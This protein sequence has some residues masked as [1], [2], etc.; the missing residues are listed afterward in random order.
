MCLKRACSLSRYFLE[1]NCQLVAIPMI[2]FGNCA[3]RVPVALDGR[4]ATRPGPLNPDE[5]TLLLFIK[6]PY[7]CALF[8]EAKSNVFARFL[9]KGCHDLGNGM[10]T[11]VWVNWKIGVVSLENG[12][13]SVLYMYRFLKL[14]VNNWFIIIQI[15]RI[16]KNN[17][18]HN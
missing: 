15:Y 14:K 3:N 5:N 10:G 17:I 12:T 8:G 11:S 1:T 4:S 7:V 9:V 18:K 16:N 2:L 6:G 13:I